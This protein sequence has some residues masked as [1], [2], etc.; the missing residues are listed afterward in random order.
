MTRRASTRWFAPDPN[1]GRHERGVRMD[2][3]HVA[4]GSP[5]FAEGA[6]VARGP[7]SRFVRRAA[8]AVVG[9]STLAFAASAAATTATFNYT[10]AAQTWTV[11]AGVTSATFDLY[12]AQ[13]GG[14]ADDP[15]APRDS[16]AERRRRSRSPPVTR[17]RSTSAV[18][19]LAP[20]EGF[21]GGGAGGGAP[22]RRRRRRLRHP[23][24]RLRRRRLPPR[25]SRA[26]RRR[27]RGGRFRRL[28]LWLNCRRR[29]R[30]RRV[31]SAR[32]RVL[33]HP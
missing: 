21:N 1:G 26:R 33:E 11:P 18:R 6:Q 28:H 23:R 8:L 9:L 16:A 15:D 22:R 29:R 30:G 5:G 32:W 3:R 31:R 10:G 17:S 14:P 20:R 2:A 25:G 12:G 13:G 27:R 4:A 7:R 24:R 19:Q